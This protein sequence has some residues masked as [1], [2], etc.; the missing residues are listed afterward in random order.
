MDLGVLRN[1]GH[2][3]KVEV[4]TPV[5][6]AWH[7]GKS[8]I[9]GGFRAL[10]TFTI[11]DRYPKPRIHETL[12]QLSH[13][14]FFAAMDSLKGSQQDV[15]AD[16]SR[17]VLSIIVHFGIYEELRMPFGIKMPLPTIQE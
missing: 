5:V 6:I 1:I 16:N 9:V 14:K 10:N 2:N 15:L 4:T 8:R 13:D 12:S 17:K 7:N 3:A 11:P